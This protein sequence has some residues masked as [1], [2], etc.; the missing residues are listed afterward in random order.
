MPGWSNLETF[1]AAK[2]L[3]TD[4]AAREPLTEKAF[5]AKS[6]RPGVSTLDW[7][8]RV[9]G[10]VC[11]KRLQKNLGCHCPEG[12]YLAVMLVRALA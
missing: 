4:I 8:H 3:G 7:L 2:L 5:V 6:Y 1:E 12:G 11:R 9:F 10:H